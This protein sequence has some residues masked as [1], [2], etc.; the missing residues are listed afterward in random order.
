MRE[1]Q[2]HG[3]ENPQ[4]REKLDFQYLSE[5]QIRMVPMEN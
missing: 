5:L 1:L 4:T 2:V 3:P